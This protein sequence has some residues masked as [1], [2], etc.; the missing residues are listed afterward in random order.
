MTEKPSTPEAPAPQAKTNGLTKI[1]A[2]RQALAKLG[3]NAKPLEL[4]GYIKKEFGIEMTAD[5]VSTSK[6]DILR[7]KAAKGKSKSK[8]KAAPKA[9]APVRGEAC[10]SEARCHGQKQWQD[11][12]RH[13]PGRHCGGQGFGRSGGPAQLRSLVDLLTK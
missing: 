8:A 1:E 13:R 3:K 11:H 5:H 2:V 10:C 6:G 9:A 4:Q 7:K 12:G